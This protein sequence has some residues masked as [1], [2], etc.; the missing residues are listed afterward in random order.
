MNKSLF[1]AIVAY[2]GKYRETHLG[3]LN[4]DQLSGNFWLALDYFFSR[5]C[6]QGRR[7]E[8]SAKVY[9]AVIEVL[10]PRFDNRMG[11]ANYE[12][13]NQHRWEPV[14][15]ALTARIGRGHVGKARDIEMVLSAL[16]FIERAPELNIVRYSVEQ[17]RQD[18]LSLHFAELQRSKSHDG[19]VQVGPKIAA[20]YLRDIVS[21]FQ[22]DDKMS[23]QNG[24]CLQPVD[25][26]V[27]KLARRL[28][29]V[30]DKANDE[31]IQE[32]IVALCESNRASP[33]LFNQ[34]A[35]YIGY[36]SF[37]IVLDLLG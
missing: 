7:D 30:D 11:T 28:E 19:I 17:I 27:R 16:D 37:D 35:W 24:Y 2:G 34:G 12:M 22:L 14:K 32:A 9:D 18:K 33:I 20:L 36:Y 13:L 8:V 15:E 4:P 29:I 26:W 23:A 25:T 10:K 6:F 3:D 31:A 21:L 5:A 1:D